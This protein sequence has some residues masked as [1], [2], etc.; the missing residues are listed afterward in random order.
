[1]QM[2]FQY[3]SEL[4]FRDLNYFLIYIYVNFDNLYAIETTT[5]G[6]LYLGHDCALRM[7]CRNTS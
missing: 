3:Q 4:V 1:M 5:T 2:I 7:N 6:W